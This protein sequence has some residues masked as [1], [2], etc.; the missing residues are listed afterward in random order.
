MRH[1]GARP[2][3]EV[4]RNQKPALRATNSVTTHAPARQP[5]KGSTVP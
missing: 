1:L 5:D 4:L 3:T 2:T